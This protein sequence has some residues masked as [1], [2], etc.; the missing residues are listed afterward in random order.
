[1]MAAHH[2][3]VGAGGGTKYQEQLAVACAGITE[4]STAGFTTSEHLD[5]LRKMQRDSCA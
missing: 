2:R 3:E 4:D 5:Q 1:M